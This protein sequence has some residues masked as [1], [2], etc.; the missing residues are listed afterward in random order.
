MGKLLCGLF[1]EGGYRVRV[2]DT[3]LGSISWED[4]AASD[5]VILAIPIPQM[6]K[7]ITELGPHTRRDGVV[8]DIASVKESPVQM[9]RR[10]CNG[11]VIGSHPLFGPSVGS[12]EG[13]VLFLCSSGSTEWVEW[14]RSFYEERGARVVEIDP[15]CHDRLMASVQV[16]RHLTLFCFGR[17]LMNVGFD[18][19]S[20]LP[21]AGPWFNGLVAM[22]AHQVEQPPE[23]YADIALHN[24]YMA[25]AVEGFRLSAEE[26]RSA[27]EKA[28]RSEMTRVMG[29][30]SRYVHSGGPAGLYRPEGL[31]RNPF[32]KSPGSGNAEETGFPLPQE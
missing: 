10:H 18:L 13:Q 9:L 3:A 16:L 23:L 14:Y 4:V 12:M 1:G 2:A 19:A 20:E 6:E 32:R 21:N 5:A 27:Y 30:I 15:A 24:S 7:A 31:G 25:S 29:E 28:D 8:I 17:A 22:L 11:E 26:L